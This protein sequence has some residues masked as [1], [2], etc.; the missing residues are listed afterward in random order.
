[1]KHRTAVAFGLVL[2]CVGVAAVF[3]VEAGQEWEWTVLPYFWAADM[4][5]DVAID[6]VPVS[7]MDIRAKDLVDTV[8]TVVVAYLEGRRGRGGLFLDVSYLELSDGLTPGG[9]RVDVDLAQTMLEAGGL[10]RL[11]GGDRGLDVLFGVRVFDLD[12]EMDITVP[13]ASQAES[14]DVTESMTDGIVGLRYGGPI[15]KKWSYAVRADI[16]E[17]DTERS[18]NGI[19]RFGYRLGATGKYSLDLGWRYL[20]FEIEEE[21]GGSRVDT[22]LAM[23]GPGI[24]FRISF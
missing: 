3:E 12:Q 7:S 2:S 17:G 13:G 14:V 10:Y 4:S 24:G 9:V 18:L 15:G 19:L 21:D 1:M 6:D 8:E 11:T 20:K 5:V 23:S 16:G 22:D